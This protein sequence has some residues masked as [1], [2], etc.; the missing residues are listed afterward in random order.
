YNYKI[1]EIEAKLKERNDPHQKIKFIE[2]YI[3]KGDGDYSILPYLFMKNF[4]DINLNEKKLKKKRL[5]KKANN[6]ISRLGNAISYF[7]IRLDYKY[8]DYLKN[9]QPNGYNR[10]QPLIHFLI[11]LSSLIRD[12]EEEIKNINQNQDNKTTSIHDTIQNI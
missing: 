4:I 3:I 7:K 6:E 12:I 8:Q 5:I 10:E 2:D 9:R 11:R 1:L